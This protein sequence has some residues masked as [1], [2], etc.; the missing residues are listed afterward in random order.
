[1]YCNVC[2]RSIFAAAIWNS[3]LSIKRGVIIYTAINGV[4]FRTE[5]FVRI[6]EASTLGSV[7]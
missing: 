2:A 7:R 4:L 1:M 3:E 5:N 6:N